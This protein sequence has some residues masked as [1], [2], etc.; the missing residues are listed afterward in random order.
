MHADA[1][2]AADGNPPRRLLNHTIDDSYMSV[3]PVDTNIHLHGFEG[4]AAE[5]NIFLSTLSTPMHACE[6]RITIPATQPPG[7]YFYHPH[8]H[9]SAGTEVALGLSGAWIVEPDRP[10]IERSA[11]HVVLL[12]YRLPVRLDNRFVPDDGGAVN[13]DAEKHEMALNDATPV[14]YDP[15]NPPSWPVTYPMSGGGVTLD[16]SGCNGVA[17]EPMVSVD[18]SLAPA[19]LDVPA[20]QVQLLRLIDATSDSPKRLQLRDAAGRLQPLHVVGLDGI[21]VSGNMRAPL[22]QYLAMDYVMLAPMARA[23]VLVTLGAGETLT[24]SSEHYC[25][26]AD[27]FFQMHH[28]VLRIHGVT[29]AAQETAD[30]IP[31]PVVRSEMPAAKLVA[32]VRANPSLVR[33]RAIT[34]TEYSFPKTG[35]TPEHQSYYITDTTDRHFHEHPFRPVYAPGGMA[36]SNA[37]VVVRAGSIE[38]WYLINATMESHVFHIHQMS[39]VQEASSAGIPVTVDTTFVRV[40][41]FLPNRR[42]PNYPLIEPSITKIVLDFRHVPKGTFV[43]HCHMLFHEDNGMMATIRVV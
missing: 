41:T 29:S 23:D 11:D 8:A 19:A 43:F 39:Y 13:A 1:H 15:F 32:F 38:E 42:D 22:T 24:L 2:V 10:Q 14:S 5:E 6:Y 37:D 30:F 3:K 17:P 4:P 7:T 28:D 25:E 18:G 9:G 26:G 34:F 21:P 40:G 20:G 16:P 12:R 31:R 27:A 35:K 36:P 33:R